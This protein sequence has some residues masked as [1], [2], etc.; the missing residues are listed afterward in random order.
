MTRVGET[1]WLALGLL[2]NAAF[3][4]RFVIQWLASERAGASTIPR[5]FWHLSLVG[6][7]LL[8]AHAIHRRDPIFVFANLPNAAVYLRNPAP[9]RAGD[10]TG[11]LNATPA[12]GVP[13][14][15]PVRVDSRA[16]PHSSA[17]SRPPHRSPA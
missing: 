14:A 11:A 6:S 4:L 10:G 16:A 5:V 3:C 15:S 12:P 2:G 9:L 8:L 13:R 1:A 7:F 17:G